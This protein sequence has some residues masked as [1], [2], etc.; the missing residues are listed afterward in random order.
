M[1]ALPRWAAGFLGV[2]LA[3][4]SNAPEG[5]S[6]TRTPLEQP[7]Y[8]TFQIF[9]A[10]P[11][12]TTEEGRHV[13]TRLPDP[14]FLGDE[15]QSIL[16]AVGERGDGL[17][18]L[19]IVVGPL[20]LDYSDEQLRT[21]IE[22][23]F[24][25]ASKDKI[26]VGF[27]IDDS[28]FWMRRS[29]LWRNPANVE[30]PDWKGTPN[31][32]QYLNWGEPWK[33]APQACFNSPD[34]VKE[35]RRISRD[36]IGPAIAAGIA[37]LRRSGDEELFAGVIVGWE[38][39]IGRDYDTG[40][41]LGYCALTNLRY[42]AKSPPP[43]FDRALD[44]VVQSWIGLWSRGLADAGVPVDK[45]YSHIAFTP[46][47]RFVADGG[48]D[49]HGV[50]A[51]LSVAFGDFHRPGFSTY[52]SAERFAEIYAALKAH[53]NSNWASAEGANVDID[54]APPAIPAE[55]MEDYLARMFNHGATLTNVFG[56]DVGD[57][58]N[59]FRRAAEGPELLAA[60]RKFL[61]GARLAEKPLAQ[62]TVGD[63]SLLQRLIHALPGRIQS[64]VRA[65]G[66]EGVMRPKVAELEQNMKQGRLDTLKRNLDQV[67]AMIDAQVASAAKTG[68]DVAALQR[69]VRALPQEIAAYQQRNGDMNR[70]KARVDS[71]QKHIDAG[72]LA[73]AYEEIQALKPIL[74]SP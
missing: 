61:S 34:M 71:I 41:R 9:T 54:A 2:A 14:A 26:A 27:H 4:T 53:G 67:E 8:L 69:D 65:G 73:Q 60:Y 5:R 56:W 39:A 63:T 49:S 22:R 74:A 66:S 57:D 70:I 11:G 48:S 23:T 72:E 18:R 36:V 38:T 6:Q 10:G 46:S 50:L 24:E 62:S 33:L 58:A 30:W 51:P 16:D 32:G 13:F 15:A 64:Y 31:A 40:R 44:S 7:Q 3:A 59:V 17:H 21:L 68:F 12:M 52:P 25:V 55:T 45:I 29:D 37:D 28:K 47:K 1:G 35:A 20:T 43:D 42:S 19:G